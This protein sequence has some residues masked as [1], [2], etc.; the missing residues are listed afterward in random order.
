MSKGPKF[1]LSIGGVPF[2]EVSVSIGHASTARI[3]RGHGSTYSVSG[4]L[5][6]YPGAFEKLLQMLDGLPLS[7][8]PRGLVGL[9]PDEPLPEPAIK[10][11]TV[12]RSPDGG[13]GY[14]AHTRYID[15]IDQA[16]TDSVRGPSR[17]QRVAALVEASRAET[18]PR[19]EFDV[20]HLPKG[21]RMQVARGVERINRSAPRSKSYARCAREAWAARMGSR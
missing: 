15:Q 6:T 2:R 4:T 18:P 8:P 21:K 1:T 9:P 17:G 20:R 11:D 3:S 19:L 16:M 10:W 14:A 5:K 12:L 13:V 7:A